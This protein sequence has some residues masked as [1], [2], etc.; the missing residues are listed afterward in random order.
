MKPLYAFLDTNVFLH[1]Q[2]FDQIKWTEVLGTAN[3]VLVTTP[4]VIRELDENKD[5]HRISAIRDRARAALKKIE[6]IALGE[7]ATRLLDGVELECA[8][9][10]AID[11]EKYGLRREINDDHLVASCLTYRDLEPDVNLVL[12]SGDTGPRLK[13]RQ[14]GINAASLPEQ[15]KLPSALDAAEKEKKQLQRRLQQLENRSPKLK[16]TF[17]GGADHLSTTVLHPLA[18]ADE[19]IQQQITNIK[20][21]YS[22]R[23]VVPESEPPQDYSPFSNLTKIQSLASTL[24]DFGKPSSG[25]IRRYNSELERFYEE[26]EIYLREYGASANLQ[27]R[28]IRLDLCLV[29]DGTAPT[30]DIDV[31][32]HFPDGFDLYDEDSRPQLPKAPDPPPPPR[33]GPGIIQDSLIARDLSYLNRPTTYLPTQSN[34]SAPE[35]KR[36]NSY[37]VSYEVQRLKQHMNERFDPLYVVFDSFR[38]AASFRI[39]YRI[40]AA[41]I[42]DETTGTLNVIV[43]RDSERR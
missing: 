31:F 2:P 9:E 19:K 29:N 3:V 6:Q 37:D 13:A 39:D 22:K 41:D 33:T 32:L 38:D 25:E 34:V 24:S 12:V 35:I 26:Y 10:P 1:Y 23:P 21:K 27:R 42:P 14:H 36:S 8:K 11:F 7:M 4:V 30:E 16:L 5:Q 28:T 18:V 17:V 20:K 43:A 15:Y 40:N